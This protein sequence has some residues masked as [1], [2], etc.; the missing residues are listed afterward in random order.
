MERAQDHDV[1]FTEPFER[2][3]YL[4]I[5]GENWP[6]M[7]LQWGLKRGQHV[8]LY[9]KREEHNWSAPG[10]VAAWDGDWNMPTLTGSVIL[11]DGWHGWIRRGEMVSA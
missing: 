1:F 7:L 2:G 11:P 3:R 4:W 6:V 8:A 9:T 5:G 10:R